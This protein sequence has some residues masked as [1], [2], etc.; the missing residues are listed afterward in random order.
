VHALQDSK[1]VFILMASFTAPPRKLPPL[2]PRAGMS[3]E[4]KEI[5]EIKDKIQATPHLLSEITY[6]KGEKSE[7]GVVAE[8]PPAA[9]KSESVNG[10]ENNEANGDETSTKDNNDTPITHSLRFRFELPSSGSSAIPKPSYDVRPFAPSYQIEFP[11]D[12]TPWGKAVIEEET[13]TNFLTAIKDR[14]IHLGKKK[15]A[16]QNY[17]EERK[18]S[19]VEIAIARQQAGRWGTTRAIWIKARLEKDEV[20]DPNAMRVSRLW[21]MPGTLSNPILTPGALRLHDR[22]PVHRYRRTQRRSLGYLVA[23]PRHDGEYS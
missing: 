10:G 20:L 12:M 17:I 6:T 13:W 23:P 14:G 11:P 2:I 3:S 21:V 7:R 19:P 1:T 15:R 16:V 5:R 22:L 18:Q 4:E 9:E 8:Q